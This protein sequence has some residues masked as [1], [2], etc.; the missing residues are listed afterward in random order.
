L[1]GHFCPMQ[2]DYVIE[3]RQTYNIR[4][5]SSA[6]YIWPKLTRSRSVGYLLVIYL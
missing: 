4:E 2:A 3:D 1:L 5:I 6:S